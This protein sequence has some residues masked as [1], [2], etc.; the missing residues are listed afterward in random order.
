MVRP[1][2]YLFQYPTGLAGHRGAYYDYLFGSNGCFVEASSPLIT[3]RIPIGGCEIRGFAPVTT[4]VHLTYGLIPRHLWDLALETFLADPDCEH[5]AGVIAENGYRLYVPAQE[6]HEA[7]VEYN[8]GDHVIL[9]LHSHANMAA[10]FSPKDNEDETAFKLYAVVGKLKEW[11]TVRL[12]VGVY[13]NFYDLSWSEVFEGALTGAAEK[14]E[15]E[16][17]PIDVYCK[18]EA[19]DP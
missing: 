6:C 8:I 3:A 4:E 13:G 2:G 1:V 14:P 9:D 5:Y 16:V 18:P 19:H 17:E 11:P 10:G 12:R 7:K 15:E